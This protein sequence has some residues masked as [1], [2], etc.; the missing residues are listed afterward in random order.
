[1][2]S[3]EAIQ[4]RNRQ[5][6]LDVSSESVLTIIQCTSRHCIVSHFVNNVPLVSTSMAIT[7]GTIRDMFLYDICMAAFVFQSANLSSFGL[8]SNLFR[9][10][11]GFIVLIPYQVANRHLS[12]YHTSFLMHVSC[13]PTVHHKLQ[14]LNP[15]KDT[16]CM[17]LEG[18]QYCAFDRPRGAATWSLVSYGR[19][20]DLLHSTPIVQLSRR[21]IPNALT[22]VVVEV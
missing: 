3:R 8:Q 16:P 6:L 14:S 19:H 12:N 15:L 11:V 10:V 21:L 13:C 5:V 9:L 7:S 22:V 4:R 18:G 2:G 20:D 17:I 1:M